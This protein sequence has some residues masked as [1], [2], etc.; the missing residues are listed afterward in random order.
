MKIEIPKVKGVTIV[1]RKA[2]DR[3]KPHGLWSLVTT[4]R[5]FRHSTF[6]IHYYNK[7]EHFW[8]GLR[9]LLLYGLSSNDT[10]LPCQNC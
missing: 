2:N 10:L 7:D 8:R 5:L 9:D 3:C 1:I 4:Q 6:H